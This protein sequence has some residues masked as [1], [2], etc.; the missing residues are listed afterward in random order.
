VLDREAVFVEN[1]NE[2]PE[3]LVGAGLLRDDTELEV[4]FQEK[5]VKLR[6]KIEMIIN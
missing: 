1:V 5:Y 2:I 4:C 6:K 3:K